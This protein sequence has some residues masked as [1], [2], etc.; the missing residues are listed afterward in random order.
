VT[1]THEVT[2]DCRR[3]HNE[4]LHYMYSSNIIRVSKSRR[5]RWAGY[6]ARIGER[7][8]AYRVL[9]GKPEGKRP[10][11]RHRRRWEDNIEM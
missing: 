4:E 11:G 7:R 9:G 2:G 6:V 3:L 10:S 1:K 5:I 8:G